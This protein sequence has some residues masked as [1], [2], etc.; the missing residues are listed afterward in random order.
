MNDLSIYCDGG[1]R[2]NPGPAASAFVVV[3]RNKVI[4][5][6]AKFIG[7]A[8]NNTAEYTA[9]TMALKWLVKNP[10]VYSRISINIFLDSELVTRQLEGKYKIKNENL[11]FLYINAKEQEKKIESVIR[12]HSVPR[13]KNK[14]PDFLVN[15]ELDRNS[16]I[17]R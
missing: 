12:Y 7:L 15:K 3:D 6:D 11:R 14:L 5:K 17:S 2:G 9:V 4:Y 1:A 16:K 8:T 13:N 10:S